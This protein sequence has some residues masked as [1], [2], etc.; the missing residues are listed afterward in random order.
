[1]S[2]KEITVKV[3]CSPNYYAIHE[4]NAIEFTP[5]QDRKRTKNYAKSQK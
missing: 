1:M 3:E 4:R 2:E 5:F